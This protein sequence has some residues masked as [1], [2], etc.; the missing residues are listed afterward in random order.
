MP[1]TLGF[2]PFS[3][4]R[5]WKSLINR[6]FQPALMKA[7]QEVSSGQPTG[8]GVLY[9]L[10]AFL[11]TMQPLHSP[12]GSSVDTYTT[13]PLGIMEVPLA[14]FMFSTISWADIFTSLN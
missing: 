2:T 13:L 7:D 1:S 14:Y 3:A 11:C 8:L 10:Q 9:V 12:S 5:L 6:I 4:P